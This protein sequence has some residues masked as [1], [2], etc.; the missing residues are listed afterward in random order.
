MPSITH[1][2]L[3]LIVQRGLEGHRFAAN[4][5]NLRVGE[6]K[7]L[8]AHRGVSGLGRRISRGKTSVSPKFLDPVI[9]ILI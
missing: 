9:S 4:G 1:D 7:G 5:A 3:S 6:I 2:K 8:R